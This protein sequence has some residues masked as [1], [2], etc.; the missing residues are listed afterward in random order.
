M[1]EDIPGQ[2]PPSKTRLKQQMLDLQALGVALVKL[3][4][5]QF[6]SIPLPENLA[7]AIR[8]ARRITAHEGRRRQMQYVG[9]LMRNVDPEPIRAALA[10]REGNSTESKVRQQHLERWR[11]RLI[12]DDS[13]LTEYATSHPGT[14][15]Q[16]MRTLI[17][18]ARKEIAETK[19]PRAQRE[20]FRVLRDAP[21]S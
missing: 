20:L 10:E 3:P 5:S 4:E 8:E 16:A 11:S 17:R 6:A 13:A 18:N 2:E 19:P 7:I 21:F 15:I 12:E 1:E 9:K 14:D